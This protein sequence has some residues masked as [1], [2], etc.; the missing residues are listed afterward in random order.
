M[1]TTQILK[2]S[3]GILKVIIFAL[4]IPS[5]VLAQT[6]HIQ[7]A[8]NQSAK[9]LYSANVIV[10]KKNYNVRIYSPVV[11]KDDPSHYQVI[12]KPDSHQI[13]RWA[14]SYADTK[15][16]FYHDYNGWRIRESLYELKRTINHTVGFLAQLAA[17]DLVDKY[18]RE[19]SKS[20]AQGLEELNDA[21]KV[22]EMAK[23]QWVDGHEYSTEEWLYQAKKS[24]SRIDRDKQKELSVEQFRQMSIEMLSCEI[25][26][27]LDEVSKIET[28]NL[29][30]R[31]D[32]IPAEYPRILAHELT[33]VLFANYKA[34]KERQSRVNW[35]KEHMDSFDVTVNKKAWAIWT[36][37]YTSLD[38]ATQEL[39]VL[40]EEPVDWDY[41]REVQE[42]RQ[43]YNPASGHYNVQRGKTFR[44]FVGRWLKPASAASKREEFLKKLN[45]HEKLFVD[46]D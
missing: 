27:L 28:D 19:H 36:T 30:H 24:Q 33:Y 11:D 29:F 35:V 44:E 25:F 10:Q 6:D 20:F 22:F 3:R 26:Y 23:K 1:E 16:K 18:K 4:I 32:Y 9:L 38:P 8:Q 46:I 2:I 39:Q 13:E 45:E 15:V 40:R 5:I 17:E 41:Y 42:F 31:W 12:P 14:I 34:Y 43:T 37:C 7:L 21:L